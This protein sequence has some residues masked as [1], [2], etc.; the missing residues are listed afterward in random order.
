MADELEAMSEKLS[1]PEEEEGITVSDQDIVDLDSK[2]ECCPVGQV[3]AE[4][5]INKEAFKMLMIKLWKLRGR[6]VF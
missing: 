1:L 4:K 5:Q 6:A 3:V 2:G